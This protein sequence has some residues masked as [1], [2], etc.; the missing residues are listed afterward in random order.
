MTGAGE[1]EKC[2]G[3]EG[4]RVTAEGETPITFDCGTDISEIAE[5]VRVSWFCLARQVDQLQAIV[6]KTSKLDNG[7]IIVEGM[8]VSVPSNR[9]CA[10][11][12]IE[13]PHI[14]FQVCWI[15]AEGQH[16]T[17]SYKGW[18]P[19]RETAKKEGE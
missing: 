4:S 19:T 6:C 2:P 10:E 17:D 14:S 18:E 7:T 3:C 5:V 1:H 15:T 11:D 16:V 9:P 12:F 13:P 8:E